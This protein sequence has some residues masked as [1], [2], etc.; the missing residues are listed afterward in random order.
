MKVVD[1]YYNQ[2]VHILVTLLAKIYIFFISVER[3]DAA[4]AA[5]AVRQNQRDNFVA[6]REG[7][8]LNIHPHGRD[9][10]SIG[11]KRGRKQ[12]H[13]RW[14]MNDVLTMT[15]TIFCMYIFRYCVL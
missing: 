11:G 14:T 2:F 12:K 6:S 9:P 15:I 8:K 13:R 7:K 10:R 5:A 1:Y 4:A 3:T